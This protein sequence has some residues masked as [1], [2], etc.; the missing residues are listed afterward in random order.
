MIYKY[1]K[2]THVYQTKACKYIQDDKEGV[3]DLMITFWTPL[4]FKAR[5]SN[6][7]LRRNHKFWAGM[8]QH[9]YDNI[10]RQ[11]LDDMNLDVEKHSIVEKETVGDVVSF[12][13]YESE[14]A[15]ENYSVTYKEWEVI[16][17]ELDPDV[18]VYKI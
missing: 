7:L 13:I 16:D 6:F 12:K 8:H 11:W 14:S 1:K 5:E 15:D 10:K 2:T 18:G 4:N 9:T 3:D 17:S